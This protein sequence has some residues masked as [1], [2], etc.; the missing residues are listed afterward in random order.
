MK[1]KKI[2]ITG[3][4]KGIGF[5]IAQ[6]LIKNDK[7][8]VYINGRK[9]ANLLKAKKKLINCSTILGDIGKKKYFT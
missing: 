3:S 5:A 8:F 9:K 7:N 4:T 6:K 1:E 2:L